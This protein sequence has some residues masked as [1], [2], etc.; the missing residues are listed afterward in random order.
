MTALV[1]PPWFKWAMKEVGTRELPENRGPAIE[2]YISLGHCG[3]LGDPWC[4]IFVNAAL[5]DNG[6]KGSRSPMARSFEHDLDFVRLM[7]PALGCIVTMWRGI[8]GGMFGH[9][10]FYNGQIG[11]YISVLGGNEDDA[12]QTMLLRA[13]GSTFGLS[14]FYWPKAIPI[15]ALGALP[16]QVASVRGSGKVV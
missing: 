7:S 16:V 2:R 9:C 3:H 1:Q 10:G 15:P 6:V 8:K 13:H 14:G 11:D 4:A 12:V 5:E